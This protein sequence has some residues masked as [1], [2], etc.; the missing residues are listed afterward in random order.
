MV[1]TRNHKIIRQWAMTH[2]A[3][4]A[5]IMPLKFDGEPTILTFLMG[6]AKA[7]TPEIRPIKWESF[8]ARFDLLG[9][10]FA[11]DQRSP[12]FELVRVEMSSASSLTH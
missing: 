7:G 2:D 12:Q 4:P 5:E 9:L 1:P 8:F 3:T 10:S 6:D 11:F